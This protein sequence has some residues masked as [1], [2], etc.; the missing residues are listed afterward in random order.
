MTYHIRSSKRG[1]SDRGTS[2]YA[3]FEILISIYN[4]YN[5]YSLVAHPVGL[6][7]DYFGS[8]RALEIKVVLVN[9]SQWDGVG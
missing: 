9:E 7:C 8:N 3:D 4:M 5:S 6:H 2:S 1:L